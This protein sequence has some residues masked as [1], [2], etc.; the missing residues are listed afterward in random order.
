MI[1]NKC[2]KCFVSTGECL[3]LV[4]I[5]LNMMFLKGNIFPQMV[6]CLGSLT[7][8]AADSS[9]LKVVP[10]LLF[11]YPQYLRVAGVSGSDG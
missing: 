6:K 4:H 11:R 8:L 1:T 10:L 9:K 7:I 5:K 3:C 2:Y